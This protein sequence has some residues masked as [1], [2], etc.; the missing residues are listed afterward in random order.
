[1]FNL[2]AGGKDTNGLDIHCL[3]PETHPSCHPL[4]LGEAGVIH[5][6][7]HLPFL[8]KPKSCGNRGKQAGFAFAPFLLWTAS[9][10]RPTLLSQVC[11]PQEGLL[12]SRE[13]WPLKFSTECGT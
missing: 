1:M 7:H 9:L 12:E 2:L 11:F 3:S 10:R 13:T 4:F 5:Q 8:S 6:P